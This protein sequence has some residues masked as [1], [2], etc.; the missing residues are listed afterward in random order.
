MQILVPIL[1][2]RTFVHT[3][4]FCHS[5]HVRTYVCQ[6][7]L[8]SCVHAVVAFVVRV[9]G[10]PVY[11]ILVVVVVFVI[12]YIPI[13]A[14]VLNIAY[15]CIVAVFLA[16]VHIPFVVYACPCCCLYPHRLCPQV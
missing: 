6:L 9:L 4:G 3:R 14:V 16:I 1:H 2:V 10:V 12:V 5:I 15:I 7:E 11:I 8:T 13:A